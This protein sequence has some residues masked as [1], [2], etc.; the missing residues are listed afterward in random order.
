M[1]PEPLLFSSI[2]TSLTELSAGVPTLPQE[3]R[4]YFSLQMSPAPSLN[5]HLSSSRLGVCLFYFDSRAPFP[6]CASLASNNCLTE[7]QSIALGPPTSATSSTQGHTHSR[8]TQ[9]VTQTASTT[10]DSGTS[11]SSGTTVTPSA[12]SHL[13]TGTIT[14]MSI[15]IG[16]VAI[17]LAIASFLYVRERA[18]NKNQRSVVPTDSLSGS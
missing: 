7:E 10:S 6:K 1:S 8:T 4:L 14:G 13:S 18:R 11:M 2:P 17:L 16:V 12:S 9:G 3:P 5:L 15:G